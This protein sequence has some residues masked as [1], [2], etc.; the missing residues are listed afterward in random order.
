LAIKRLRKGQTMKPECG[1]C[2]HWSTSNPLFSATT[3][4]PLLGWGICSAFPSEERWRDTGDGAPPPR[5]QAFL[6]TGDATI[7]TL[8]TFYCANYD[9]RQ[10]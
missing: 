8:E 6:D 2:R 4:E 3:D 7:Y 10:A 1:N 5:V 9:A